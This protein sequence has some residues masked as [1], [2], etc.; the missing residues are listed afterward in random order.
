MSRTSIELHSMPTKV[1]S[2]PKSVGSLTSLAPI[3]R[4]SQARDGDDEQGAAAE[5]SLPAPVTS[6]S[7][8]LIIILSTTLVTG[9]GSM[10]NGMV[11]VSLPQ[12]TIDLEIPGALQ[13][14][15]SSIQALTCG[16]TLLLSGSLADTLG[17]R[18]MYLTGCVLQAGFVLGCGLS[19]TAT[20]LILFRALSGVSLSFCLPSAVSIITGSFSGS[21]RNVAFATMGGGQPVGFAIG[22]TLGGVLTETIGWRVGFYIAAAINAVIFAIGFFGLPKNTTRPDGLA[23]TWHQK[24]ERVAH[25]IDWVGAII[26]STSLAMLSYVF[27]SITGSTSNIREPSSIALLSTAFA[28]IPCFIVWVGRQERLGRPAI[29]P[30]SL[31]RTRTFTTICLAVFMTWGAFNAQETITTFFFQHAQHL[32]PIQASIRFLP[33]PVTGV[34]ANVLIGLLVS[35]VRADVLVAGACFIACFSA[36]PLITASPGSSYWSSAFI[37]NILLP[38]APDSLFTIS[39]L[40]IT[41][42][43]PPKTQG[44]AGGVFNTISQIGKSVGLAL[45]AVIASSVTRKSDYADKK[46]AEALMVG[47]R[48]AYWY[49]FASSVVTLL[50]VSWGL[51]RI[52]KVGHKRD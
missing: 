38:I 10:L 9:I 21:R 51:R 12:L 19:K 27:A 43:F 2:A 50:L 15:P 37:A 24:W 14:W 30:N 4:E 52:G 46:D 26:A 35:R 17:S 20:D 42:S 5:A 49:C 16:C 47:Y 1:D 11:T 44:L 39:N 40:V 48:A 29:I 18:L 6:K 32:T 45:V 22:L 36:V 8:T 28:L 34:A 3:D 23:L 7:G 41:S 31:W 13:L 25:E 33:A